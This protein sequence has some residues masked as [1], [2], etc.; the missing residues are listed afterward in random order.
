VEDG[1]RKMYF[2]TFCS[3]GDPHDSGKNLLYNVKN[4]K[5]NLSYYFDEILVYT[6]RVLK[7]CD[8]SDEFCNFHHGEFMLNPGLNAVGCGDFKSFI[9]DK[10]LNE[11]EEGAYLW[12]HDCNFSKYSQ[13]WQTDWGNLEKI[14]EFLLSSNRS[15]FFMAFESLFAG[16]TNFVR[17]HG[18]R[19][20]TE[21]I[22]DDPV[23]ADLISWC[24]EIASNRILIKNTQKS[25]D[26][27]REYKELCSNKE[28]LTKFPNPN[29]YPEFTHSCPEQHVLNCL[30]YKHI[31]AGDLD[32]EFPRY[33]FDNRI[34]RIDEKLSQLQNRTL[35]AYMNSR[36]IQD[37]IEGLNPTSL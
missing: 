18:K 37:M 16:S 23:E 5:R 25:R 22:I 13:Y 14:F 35:V 28:L 6:P 31:L 15:D 32:P 29:P 19:F 4:I 9:I 24:Y 12:Y 8:G 21:K 11:I 10:T 1:K 30:V 33:M 2:L 3:E 26:F 36:S 17:S 27:F 34:F 20:T 7:S